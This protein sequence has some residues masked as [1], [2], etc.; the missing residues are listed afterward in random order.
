V[1]KCECNTLGRKRECF[2]LLLELPVT[3]GSS[4]GRGAGVLL[5]HERMR[6]FLVF[7]NSS[8]H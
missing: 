3:L 4:G 8:G 1:T 2:A 5:S 7:K 6:V